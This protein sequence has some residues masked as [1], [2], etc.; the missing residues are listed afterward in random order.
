MCGGHKVGMRGE[1][2]RLREHCLV[3]ARKVGVQLAV[4]HREVG[5]SLE[6]GVELGTIGGRRL[7]QLFCA[8]Q[9]RPR[10][11]GQRLTK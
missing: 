4:A 7:G 6:L 10:H 11:G 8:L 3:E 5:F 2:G 1:G 9:Q